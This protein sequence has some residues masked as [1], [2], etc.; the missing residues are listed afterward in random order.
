MPP[1]QASQIPAGRQVGVGL[2]LN[3]ENVV[4]PQFGPYQLAILWDGN[5]ARP[6]L[7]LF[8]EQTPPG[9]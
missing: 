2:I 3:F 9:P 6:P 8:V 4:F 1:A 5:E 7:R